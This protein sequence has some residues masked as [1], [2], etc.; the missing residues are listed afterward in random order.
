MGYLA[1]LLI[2]YAEISQNKKN[3][4]KKKLTEL[5]ILKFC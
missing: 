3:K 1:V 5:G 4:K 2:N